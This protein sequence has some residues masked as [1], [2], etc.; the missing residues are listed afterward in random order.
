MALFL[1]KLQAWAFHPHRPQ[2]LPL[3]YGYKKF[4][5]PTSLLGPRA[6]LIPF[7]NRLLSGQGKCSCRCLVT[8]CSEKSKWGRWALSW[9]WPNP[10]SSA[11]ITDQCRLSMFQPFY[12]ITPASNSH[13][14][15]LRLTSTPSFLKRP[16]RGASLQRS[17]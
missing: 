7:I 6:F 2:Q 17:L 5:L 8:S 3:F 1:R 15:D 13:L 10:L 11:E 12:A 16:T 4:E 9:E 14:W